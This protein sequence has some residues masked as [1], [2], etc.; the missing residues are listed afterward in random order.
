MKQRHRLTAVLVTAVIAVSATAVVAPTEARADSTYCGFEITGVQPG[1][2]WKQAFDEE[3]QLFYDSHLGN[4]N[5]RYFGWPKDTFCQAAWWAIENGAEGLV[6][7]AI[8]A[9]V[10]GRA[11]SPAEKW[12]FELGYEHATSESSTPASIPAVGPSTVEGVVEDTYYWGTWAYTDPNPPEWS[13]KWRP[14]ANAARWIDA[15]QSV[16]AVCQRQAAG[17]RVHFDDGAV[18]IWNRWVRLVDGSWVRTAVMAI[19][20]GNG[21]LGLP[22]C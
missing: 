22:G 17:Y 18:Q 13:P 5:D 15:G 16:T 9:V 2:D 7:G 21:D 1:Q 20:S 11:L 4:L 10:A 19:G 14:P 8:G 12:A 3:A 6:V